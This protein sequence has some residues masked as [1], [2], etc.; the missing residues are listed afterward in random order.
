[1]KQFYI[2]IAILAL[3]SV[4]IR[5]QSQK[6]E[7]GF[8]GGYTSGVMFRVNLQ[9]NLSYE[10]QLSYRDEGIIFTAYRQI[11]MDMGMDRLGNWKFIYGF[12]VHAGFY[13]TDSY[14]ILF[15]EV[16]FGQ[17]IL[18]PV[19]GFDGFVGIDYHFEDI[20]MSFGLS[21]QPF[22]EISLRQ[23]FGINLWDLGFS[24]RYRF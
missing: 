22:M 1:M 8:R 2:I 5:A 4:T 17:R 23:I 15:Q 14:K 9:E 13:Y 6:K 19:V 7:I 11:H 10:A 12:G 18:T 24:V 3:S 16:Y 21:Y 20:P